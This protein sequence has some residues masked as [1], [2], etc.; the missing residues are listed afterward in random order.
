MQ[1]SFLFK[2]NEHYK[3]KTPISYQINSMQLYWE[4][5]PIPPKYWITYI[6]LSPLQTVPT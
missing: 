1:R 2:L 6:G 3:D 4:P 5:M